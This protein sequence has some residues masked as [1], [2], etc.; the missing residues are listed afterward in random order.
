M[1]FVQLVQSEKLMPVTFEDLKKLGPRM[2]EVRPLQPPNNHVIFVTAEVS[3]DERLR[4]VRP[5]QLKNI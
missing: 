2:R 4:E 1:S 5:L 3:N